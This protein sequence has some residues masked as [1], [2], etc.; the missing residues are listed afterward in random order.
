MYCCALLL[1]HCRPDDVVSIFALSNRVL[2]RASPDLLVASRQVSIFALSNRVLLL[3][4]NAPLAVSINGFNIRSVESCTAAISPYWPRPHHTTVSI[5][6]LSNRV[7]LRGSRHPGATVPVWFQ[8]SLCRIVYCCW[9]SGGGAIAL[10]R[11]FNIRSVESCT[12]ALHPQRHP[13]RRPLFQ[14]SLCRIVY[15]CLHCSH[16]LPPTTCFNIRSV[17]SC[18]AAARSLCW[19]VAGISVSIFALSNR[20]L[21]RPVRRWLVLAMMRFNIRSVESCTAAHVSPSGAVAAKLFQYSL[22]RIVYCCD[23]SAK[24]A[25]PALRC[26][27]IR[28]VE[29]CTAAGAGKAG[30]EVGAMFQYS[31]CRIVY[32]CRRCS[33]V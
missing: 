33:V 30:G 16:H 13:P 6:A 8:Y 31:L 7:L 28:S 24:A 9:R 12:A 21:L 29:S 22:C 4:V 18:T 27:N 15:C 23:E 2:L 3:S 26:F 14:Y 11:C 17:E 32:C 5:F 19:I 25:M 20:V 1:L 10:V